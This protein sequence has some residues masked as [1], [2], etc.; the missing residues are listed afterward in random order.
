MSAPMSGGRSV[1][2]SGFWSEIDDTDTSSCTRTGPVFCSWVQLSDNPAAIGFAIFNSATYRTTRD[3]NHWGVSLEGSRTLAPGV[4]GVTQAP[5]PRTLSLGADIRGIDQDISLRTTATSLPSPV[6]YTEDLDARYYGLY[7]KWGGDYSPLLF[8][9]LWQ[10]MGLQSSFRLQ[11]GIYY[12]DTDYSGTITGFVGGVTGTNG[13]LSLSR[14][15]VAFIG[16]LT[17]ETRKQI[18]RRATLSLTSNYDY[19][20]FVPDMRYNDVNTN[21]NPLTTGPNNGT[22]IGSDDAFSMR[23]S[24]RLTV[25]LGPDSVFEGPLK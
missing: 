13:S 5:Y 22:H 9:G 16:G 6:A 23:T 3:V 19:Y 21:P 17:L 18:G 2:L 25:K 8:K 12:A 11:G 24:L 4:M 15:D 10:R 1:T 14:D 7:A 20:S